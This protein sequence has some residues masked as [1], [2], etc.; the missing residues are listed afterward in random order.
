MSVTACVSRFAGDDHYEVSYRYFAAHD[1]HSKIKA[2]PGFEI[3]IM[4]FCSYPGRYR[5]Q[6]CSMIAHVTSTTIAP[7]S[8]PGSIM[9]HNP[10]LYKVL[11]FAFS[12][13]I[14]SCTML[15]ADERSLEAFDAVEVSVPFN[16]VL[17]PARDF[18]MSVTAESHVTSAVSV[19]ISDQTLHLSTHGAFSSQQPIFCTV[20]LPANKLQAVKVLFPNI[21][22]ALAGGFYPPSVS[23]DVSGAS[24]FVAKD[25]KAANTAVSSAG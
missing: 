11:A 2:L 24:K 22:V 7:L 12:L 5:L 13:A 14:C 4:L 9:Q 20:S 23:I 17:S 8:A 6:G 19:H 15:Q 10:G 1:D 3:I 21:L 16:V 25:L 18:A